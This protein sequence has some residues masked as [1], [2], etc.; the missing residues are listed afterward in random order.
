MNQNIKN[1]YKKL[2]ELIEKCK[3][4]MII[5]KGGSYNF[6]DS[7]PDKDTL[8]IGIKQAIVNLPRKDILVMNDFEGV[9]GIE[10]IIS[11]IKIIIIPTFLRY[12]HKRNGDIINKFNKYL[13]MYNFNGI[14]LNY[15]IMKETNDE[16]L[17]KHEH[18]IFDTGEVIFNILMKLGVKNKSIFIYNLYSEINDNENITNKIKNAKVHNEFIKVYNSYCERVLNNKVSQNIKSIGRHSYERSFLID[19]SSKLTNNEEVTKIL[20]N[21]RKYIYDRFKDLLVNN[22]I[23]WLV[24]NQNLYDIDK[25]YFTSLKNKQNILNKVSAMKINE[26]TLKKIN[27][28][29]YLKNNL[30]YLSS[31]NNETTEIKKNILIL[32]VHPTDNFYLH[33]LINIHH[34]FYKIYIVTSINLDEIKAKIKN[35]INC[36]KI[37]IIKCENIGLNF[38]KEK[39]ALS[40]I[41]NSDF[42]N[43]K[44]FIIN[45]SFISSEWS[46]IINE[47]NQRTEEYIGLAF[48]QSIK[49]HFQS[50]FIILNSQ[51]IIKHYI[52]FLDAYNF[53]QTKEQLIA[54]IEVGF[55]NSILN[56]NYSYYCIYPLNIEYF[57]KK[58][59]PGTH[60]LYQ[61]TDNYSIIKRK[62]YINFKKN[63]KNV[64]RYTLSNCKDIHLFTINYL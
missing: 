30:I 59:N 24:N 64:S 47:S 34:N 31:P 27:K 18:N 56:N 20:L 4:I 37:E 3:N 15:V 55:S 33:T 48:S 29:L 26:S 23:F 44:I 49:L 53:N 40:I 39:H 1:Y 2:I 54:D 28:N 35:H 60:N 10:D 17:I 52:D 46:Y 41:K 22:K 8:Y 25:C 51:K 7:T 63:L 13:K 14:V 19:N 43:F 50:Y 6:C 61:I 42:S 57:I 11:E 12:K 45:D 16:K 62:N 21:K 36:E 5:S 32:T 38:Y 9:F 58:T